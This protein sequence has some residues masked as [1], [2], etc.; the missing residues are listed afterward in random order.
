M[1]SKELMVTFYFLNSQQKYNHTISG[2][3]YVAT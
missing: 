3:Y 1:H 2:Y